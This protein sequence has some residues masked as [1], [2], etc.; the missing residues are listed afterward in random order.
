M[1]NTEKLAILGTQDIGKSEYWKPQYPVDENCVP[2]SF[3][4]MST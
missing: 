3:Y 2:Q 4:F 1:D